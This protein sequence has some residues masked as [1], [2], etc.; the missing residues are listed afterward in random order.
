MVKIIVFI[1]CSLGIIAVSWPSLR[2]PR[3]HGF[4]RFFAWEAILG[5][6]L[7]TL[8]VWFKN[9]FSVPQIISWI[10][11]SV[12]GFLVIHGV[13]LLRVVGKPRDA[14]EDTTKLVLQGAYK[15]IRHPLYSSLLFL[16][17]GVFFKNFD[18]LNTTLVA[19]ATL[20][21][22]ATARA[23]EAENLQ[24]FGAE[25]AEYM[26]KSKMFIPFLL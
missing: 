9:P 19:V 26:K 17:W 24:K 15:Y 21:L 12:S 10:L 1:A 11:L 22:T 25:Y 14:L 13:H 18:F 3:S 20:F 6:I 5:M 16:A 4:F 7:L 23:E 8:E 2:N